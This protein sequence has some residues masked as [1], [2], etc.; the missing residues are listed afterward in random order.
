MKELWS[1]GKNLSAHSGIGHVNPDFEHIIEV[2][3][4]KIIEDFKAKANQFLA[5]Q[6][7]EKY[8]LFISSVFALLGMQRYFENYSKLAQSL[9]ANL[10]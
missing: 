10:K 9:K 7:Q 3:L 6:N 4:A 1:Q 5:A 2:G 8:H